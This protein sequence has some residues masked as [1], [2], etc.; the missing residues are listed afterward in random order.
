MGWLTSPAG[1]IIS[2]G[3]V[4]T[5]TTYGMGFLEELRELSIESGDNPNPPVMDDTAE[6][7]LSNTEDI[8]LGGREGESRPVSRTAMIRT[9][10]TEQVAH[11]FSRKA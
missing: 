7:L 2:V 1:C 9:S 11:L 3:G 10:I 4:G 5:D 6:A 8:I